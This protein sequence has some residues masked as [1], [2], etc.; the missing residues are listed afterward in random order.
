MEKR[1][2]IGHT[3][4]TDFMLCPE[5]FYEDR[6]HSEDI[7]EFLVVSKTENSITIADP[8]KPSKTKYCELFIYVESEDF[9]YEGKNVSSWFCEE[10]N[11]A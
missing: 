5:D 11:Y 8:K 2:I 9:I 1:F 4:Y 10:I 6:D 7:L 3:Y